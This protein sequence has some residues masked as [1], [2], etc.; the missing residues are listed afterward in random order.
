MHNRHTCM[1]THAHT[2]TRTCKHARTHTHTHTCAHTHTHTH[3]HTHAYTHMH[4]HLLLESFIKLHKNIFISKLFRYIPG[5]KIYGE[6][7]QNNLQTDSYL[8]DPNI[9]QRN[10]VFL[11]PDS[12][13]V[14]P[15]ASMLYV[16]SIK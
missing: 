8:Y 13:H 10:S 1:H 11:I 16:S 6:H 3:T 4:T 14:H 15:Y 2:H 7:I 9:I 12:W 5:F